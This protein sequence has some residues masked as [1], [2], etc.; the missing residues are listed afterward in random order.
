M[1][2]APSTP[3]DCALVKASTTELSAESATFKDPVKDE[4][5][6]R[7]WVSELDCIR[8]FTEAGGRGRVVGKGIQFL[9]GRNLLQGL[10]LLLRIHLQSIQDDAVH[11]GIDADAHVTRSSV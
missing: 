9:P 4:M 1:S 11:I 2:L 8:R 10:V 3:T 5:F 7:Y 6:C